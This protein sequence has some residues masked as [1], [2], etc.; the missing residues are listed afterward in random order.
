MNYQDYNQDTPHQ[1]YHQDPPQQ[2][3]PSHQNSPVLSN[4]MRYP[5]PPASES[6]NP[7]TAMIIAGLGCALL[8]FLI[9]TNKSI[10]H[11]Q[12]F[13]PIFNGIAHTT[14][15]TV[16][17]SKGTGVTLTQDRYKIGLGWDPI[18]D[19]TP[20]DVDASIFMLNKNG[21]CSENKDFIFYNNPRHY[22]GSVRSHGDNRSGD[23]K[24]DDETIDVYLDQVPPQYETLIVVVSI[25]SPSHIR[26]QHIPNC[27]IRLIDSTGGVTHKADINTDS[28][29]RGKR[30]LVMGEFK[31]EKNGW[32]FMAGDSGWNPINLKTM[33]EQVGLKSMR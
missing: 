31:R 1:G 7:M 18:R 21:Q 22:S 16:N 5:Y 3:Y 15:R 17:L 27:Y 29:H 32:S 11:D 24:G 26:F 25:E 20:V 30:A 6:T 14:S 19:G 23:A 33:C 13:E 4:Q 2:G 10:K 9:S 28:S 12:D 8:A